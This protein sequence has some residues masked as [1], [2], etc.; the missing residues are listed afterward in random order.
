MTGDL[1]SLGE[2]GFLAGLLPG[3]YSDPLLV[4]GFGH[5]ASVIELPDAPFNLIQKID[6][7]S[8]PVALKEGWSGYRSWGRMAITANCSDILASGGR[9]VACMMAIM[10]PGTE[11]ASDVRDIVLGA[12]DECRSHGVV[13]AGGDT[14]EA[15]DPHVVGTAVGVIEKDAFLPR[16]TARPGDQLFCAGLVGGFA[17]AYFM[18]KNVPREDRDHGAER[19]VEYLASP[20]AQWRAAE[21]VNRRRAARCG[22][23]ASDGILDVLQTFSS[24]GVR[25]S[26]DLDRIPYH[27]FAV[28]CARKT[29][30]PL[31]QL[32]FG[33][34]DWNILYSVP[35]GR[36]EELRGLRGGPVPLYHIGEITEGGGVAARD[37]D[38]TEHAIRGV[39]NEH[40]KSRIE[41]ASGFMDSI[42]KGRFVQ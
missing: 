18:L 35:P 24:P 25:V 30:I 23:D 33:G 3:L 27:E 17:G 6:R 2:K 4:G 13:Y 16:N 37:G 14:K 7:A 21:E 41:D 29:G 9:P 31:T 39:V 19:Y 32:I 38:G 40:F 12:A 22:M 11:R 20:V 10:V 8:Y 42:E 1:T 5:D 15:R 26:I 28:E 36:A 34:G